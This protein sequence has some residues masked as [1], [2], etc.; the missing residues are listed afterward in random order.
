MHEKDEEQEAGTTGLL[1]QSELTETL[2]DVVT[3]V[4]GPSAVADQPAQLR[5]H[6]SPIE[7]GEGVVHGTPPKRRPGRPRKNESAGS[8]AKK[9]RPKIDGINQQ[10]EINASTATFP[11]GDD[12]GIEP[13]AQICTMMVQASGMILGGEEAK[14][15]EEEIL[16]TK[17]GFV[18]YFRAKGI[19]NIPPSMMLL[20][21]LSPYYL[22]IIATTPA[23]S[24]LTGFFGRAWF[25]IK[26]FFRKRKNARSNSW[27]NSKR[28]NDISAEAGK[29]SV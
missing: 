12:A 3:D 19:Q 5:G 1:N 6:D 21:A 25:G 11:Q 15:R 26:E 28:E 4:S 9:S 20:G 22:R 8:T 13:C 10:E 27:N 16:L 29:E 2:E 17:N 18:G 14:M 7:Q 23:S 24:K